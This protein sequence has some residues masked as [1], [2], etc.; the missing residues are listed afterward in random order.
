MLRLFLVEITPTGTLYI[1]INTQRN[2]T[3]H[4]ERNKAISAWGI[5]LNDGT[6]MVFVPGQVSTIPGFAGR[7]VNGAVNTVLITVNTTETSVTGLSCSS[8]IDSVLVPSTVNV[9]VYG[10]KLCALKAL[11][12]YILK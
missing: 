4:L 12:L 7:R 11:Y 1:P 8:I 9:T 3:C 6:P 5:I 2:V 10:E